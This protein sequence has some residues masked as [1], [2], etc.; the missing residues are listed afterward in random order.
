MMIRQCGVEVAA[1]KTTRSIWDE[2][3]QFSQCNT[4]LVAIENSITGYVYPAK[5]F[6]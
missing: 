2:I 4:F 5:I 3:Y 1:G 6:M